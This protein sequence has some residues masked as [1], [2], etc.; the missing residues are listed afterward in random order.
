M[1]QISVRINL[2]LME[3]I[4]RILPHKSVSEILKMIVAKSGFIY[5]NKFPI[6]I[7]VIPNFIWFSFYIERLT[8]YAL[9]L[10]QTVYKSFLC[11]SSSLPY[12][13]KNSCLHRRHANNILPSVHSA[14]F[15]DPD[16]VLPRIQEIVSVFHPEMLL[17]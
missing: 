14:V 8:V 6:L 7:I 2:K 13:V 4:H 17:P 11:L 10:D 9:R 16:R 3:L 12:I 15:S 1:K 5:K